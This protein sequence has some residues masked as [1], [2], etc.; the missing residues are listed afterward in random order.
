MAT[1]WSL[2]LTLKSMFRDGK[3]GREHNKHDFDADYNNFVLMQDKLA[4]LANHEQ[5]HYMSS[6][7]DNL[8]SDLD[9]VVVGSAIDD[10]CT[11]KRYLSKAI[12]NAYLVENLK[13]NLDGN[14]SLDD[15][16]HAVYEKFEGKFTPAEF[17]GS[18]QYV[19]LFSG[20]NLVGS[21]SDKISE[22]DID[23]G[24]LLDT[25]EFDEEDIYKEDCYEP[26]EAY[27]LN[28][29]EIGAYYRESHLDLDDYAEKLNEFVV[30]RNF[31]KYVGDVVENRLRS[32]L[33]YYFEHEVAQAGFRVYFNRDLKGGE[34]EDLHDY[35]NHLMNTKCKFD[36]LAGYHVVDNVIRD[37]LAD[38]ADGV[39]KI[40][41][42]SILKSE[43]RAKV[44]CGVAMEQFYRDHVGKFAGT[45]VIQSF[46]D[47]DKIK[48]PGKSKFYGD[49]KEYLGYN[50]REK[51]DSTFGVHDLDNGKGIDFDDLN[52]FTRR[53]PVTFYKSDIYVSSK[54]MTKD[55]KDKIYNGLNSGSSFEAIEKSL[56]PYTKNVL[57]LSCYIMSNRASVSDI[58]Q[59]FV[60]GMDGKSLVDVYKDAKVFAKNC[61]GI[62]IDRNSYINNCVDANIIYK[63][64]MADKC[65]CMFFSDT[66]TMSD[67][68]NDI[69][70]LVSKYHVDI[71]EE[72]VVDMV[73][74]FTDDSA[75]R[76]EFSDNLKIHSFALPKRKILNVPFEVDADKQSTDDDDFDK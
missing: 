59:P 11:D 19:Q 74:N 34:L 23:D 37:K 16:A 57:E 10:A 73:S 55:I 27:Y 68:A 60:S 52:D 51:Y 15:V 70:T 26:V 49:L 1:D 62:A 64:Y 66:N 24:Y 12:E 9:N 20:D 22:Q 21:L 33:D 36:A 47:N 44:V 7:I 50:V 17:V 54:N 41:C 2:L 46:V 8:L 5:T 48:E 72:R 18:A 35:V 13:A 67:L 61:K 43:E 38:I 4:I 25:D 39:S 71:S 53:T 40:S 30:G 42:D 6:N 28:D 58:E 56:E 3:Y 31:G 65:K 29:Y 69:N 75:L 45:R 14:K 63:T 32:V 76:A